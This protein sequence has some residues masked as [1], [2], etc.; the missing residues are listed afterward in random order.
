MTHYVNTN[1]YHGM[2]TGRIGTGVLHF[3]N[4]TPIYWFSNK[5]STS[6]LQHIVLNILAAQTC[7]EQIIDQ[8]HT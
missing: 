7:I 1:L 8:N 6:E 5:Q 4:K 2:L 3:L